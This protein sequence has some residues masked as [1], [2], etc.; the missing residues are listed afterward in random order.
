MAKPITVVI[1]LVPAHDFFVAELLV[2][3]TNEAAL[4]E[5]VL[6]CRSGLTTHD[7][8]AF[9]TLLASASAAVPFPVRA[10]TTGKRQTAGENR[11]R[12][13]AAT[14]TSFIAFMDADDVYAPG[15]LSLLIDIAQS[16]NSNLVIHDFCSIEDDLPFWPGVSSGFPDIVSSGALYE[17]TFPGGRN[18]VLADSTTGEA[19]LRLPHSLRSE[20]SI[21]HGHTFVRDSVFDRIQFSGIY[22][23]EDGQFCR[24]VL[25]ELG[26]VNYIPARLSTYRPSLS[27]KNQS[28]PRDKAIRRFREIKSFGWRALRP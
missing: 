1:P 18:S 20:H 7:Q 13:A 12:G 14:R 2:S 11:N 17:A 10:L 24:A 6:I 16:Q 19:N 25:W 4:I 9:Q 27:A 22:P 26:G 15:R 3:L 8:A 23:G 21:A 28:T 5:E